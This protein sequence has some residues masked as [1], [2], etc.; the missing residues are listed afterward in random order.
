[1]AR[2]LVATHPI[3]GHVLPGIPIVAELVRRGHEVR[4]YVGAKFRDRAEQVGATFEPYVHAQDYDDAD[5]DAAF[6]GRRALTGLRQIRYDFRTIF[7]EQ[8][9][10][11]HRDLT[12]I[13]ERFPADV[14]LGDTAMIG[15]FTVNE[16]GG[17]PNA[18]YN[19]T[20]LGI[21]GRGIAPFGLGLMPDG[22]RK[23]LV[24]N[25]ILGFAA[26]NVIFGSVSRELERQ[27]RLVGVAPRKFTGPTVS[28]FLYLQPSVPSFEYPRP[29]LPP[30]VHYV[31]V[32]LPPPAA[33]PDLPDWWPDVVSSPRPVVLVTQGTVAT[34]VRDLVTPTLLGL[35]NED[36]LVVAA[37]VPDLA[38]LGIPRLPAN[39]RIAAYLP[40]SA[41]MEHV[42]VYVTNG[43]YGGVQYALAAGV[44]IVAAGTTEDKP[45][46]ANRVAYS[47]IGRNL[48]TATPTPQ[49]VRE[50]VRA[51]LDEPAYRAAA[52]RVAAE[53]AA[54]DAASES[55][56]LLER[57][58]AT[59]QPVTGS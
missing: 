19:V 35:A 10:G 24:R 16:R 21:P 5:Y 49:Q 32:L 8:V 50:A 14:T 20:C 46:V 38:S 37:G 48:D 34:A 44:P 22:S 7:V 15:P 23:G 4:W 30:Q 9:E 25:G 29:D 2:F 54:H 3:T 51:L 47:G 36:V 31:G 40:F 57:L 39:A 13:L 53:L 42:S 33:D 56:E 17:P 12:G 18:L 58:A 45:E 41:A 6:P 43:G 59:G 52:G 1:L 11:Q 28:D 27:C 26:A 55:A